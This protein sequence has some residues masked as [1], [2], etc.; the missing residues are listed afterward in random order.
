MNWSYADK[1]DDLAYAPSNL[2]DVARCLV[3]CRRR[4]FRTDVGKSY[5]AVIFFGGQSQSM[6]S[7]IELVFQCQT[8]H[9]HSEYM[10]IQLRVFFH[11]QRILGRAAMNQMPCSNSGLPRGRAMRRRGEV[12]IV[13]GTGNRFLLQ[14]LVLQA[15]FPCHAP[16]MVSTLIPRPCKKSRLRMLCISDVNDA[17]TNESRT[18]MVTV[19]CALVTL[20]M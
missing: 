16:D 7:I 3:M 19:H 11:S 20:H 15:I 14:V 4:A 12:A 13:T 5:L 2:V 1:C 8:L 6:D 9:Q 17:F 18:L 10:C